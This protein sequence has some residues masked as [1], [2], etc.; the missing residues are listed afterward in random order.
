MTVKLINITK[1]TLLFSLF[2]NF[3]TL[4]SSFPFFSPN[5]FVCVCL[6]SRLCWKTVSSL[7]LCSKATWQLRPERSGRRPWRSWPTRSPSSCS[8][9]RN[10][11]RLQGKLVWYFPLYLI[12]FA[13][14]IYCL[15]IVFAVSIIFKFYINYMTSVRK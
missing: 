6:C 8:I 13:F 14:F 9:S 3:P 12:C 15:F 2:P 7:R 1:C 4:F 11:Q 10:C 5:F